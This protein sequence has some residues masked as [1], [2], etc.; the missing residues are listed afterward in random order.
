MKLIE[1]IGVEQ[2]E[3]ADKFSI[4]LECSLVVFLLKKKRNS[5]KFWSKK[6]TNLKKI[7]KVHQDVSLFTQSQYR[8]ITRILFDLGI[9]NKF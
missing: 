4:D 7:R 9:K 6:K 2:N 8:Q 1:A 5:R 3:K